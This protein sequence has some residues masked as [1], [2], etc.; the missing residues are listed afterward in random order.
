MAS[1][2]S[3]LFASADALSWTSDEWVAVLGLDNALASTVKTTAHIAALQILLSGFAPATG[4]AHPE[5]TPLGPRPDRLQAAEV[6]VPYPVTLTRHTQLNAW[7]PQELSLVAWFARVLASKE[8]YD[9]VYD[10]ARPHGV[11]AHIKEAIVLAGIEA[12]TVGSGDWSA[13]AQKMDLPTEDVKRAYREHKCELQDRMWVYLVKMDI[14]DDVICAINSAVASPHCECPAYPWLRIGD[15]L[16]TQW[17]DKHPLHASRPD[18]LQ[19]VRTF[20]QLARD[21]WRYT[22]GYGPTFNT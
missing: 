9:L 1:N 4:A 8:Y 5:R 17:M 14:V 11:L 20:Y 12:M 2:G 10:P 18:V 19:A 7:T 13:I 3:P 22:R 15:R 21:Y 6:T 16:W